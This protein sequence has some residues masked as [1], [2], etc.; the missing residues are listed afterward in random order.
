MFSWSTGSRNHSENGFMIM[1]SRRIL[2]RSIVSS[3]GL[4]ICSA[5]R[6]ISSSFFS[7]A[8]LRAFAAL[9]YTDSGPLKRKAFFCERAVGGG[10][11]CGREAGETCEIHEA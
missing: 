8:S 6:S 4:L 1:S 5:S 9:K 2:Q 3:W 7:K 10:L 11:A